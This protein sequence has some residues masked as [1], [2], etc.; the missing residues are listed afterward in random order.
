MQQN[1]AEKVKLCKKLS[2]YY[3]ECKKTPKKQDCD[4]YPEIQKSSKN[5]Y[6][7]FECLK[8]AKSCLFISDY[9]IPKF[10]LVFEHQ[11][12]DL[13]KLILSLRKSAMCFEYI[14]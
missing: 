9:F 7:M 14:D 5:M 8:Y 13:K 11:K 10:P 1:G 4:L 2:D 3:N 12:K 6:F